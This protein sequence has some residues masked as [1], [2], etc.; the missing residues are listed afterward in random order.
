MSVRYFLVWESCNDSQ[1]SKRWTVR[2]LGPR[3]PVCAT[4]IFTDKY[5]AAWW[6]KQ[7]LHHILTTTGQRS[8]L[9]V[10]NKGGGT[11]KE[12]LIE[13]RKR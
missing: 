7:Y 8:R 2:A 4:P 13:K 9:V 3:G 1:T 5:A 11:W 10:L 12:V 6:T